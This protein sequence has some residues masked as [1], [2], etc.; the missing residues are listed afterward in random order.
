MHINQI[1]HK[2]LLSYVKR[3]FFFLH[4]DKEFINSWH[5]KCIISFME[6]YSKLIINLPPRTLKSLVCNL[7]YVT[8]MIGKKRN[9]K[10]IIATYGEFLSKTF[11]ENCKLILESDWYKEIFHDFAI[12]KKTPKRIQTNG[13]GH[14]VITSISGSLTGEGCDI[15]IID[16]PHKAIHA[17]SPHMLT[18]SCNWFENTLLSRLNN[19]NDCKI[20]VIM[21]RIHKFDLTGYILK[22]FDSFIHLKIPYFTNKDLFFKVHDQKFCMKKDSYLYDHFSN[23]DQFFVKDILESQYLQNPVN[24][25]ELFDIDKIQIINSDNL[26]GRIYQSW[27]T[28]ISENDHSSYSVCTIWK[29]VDNKYIL[30]DMFKDKISYQKLLFYATFFANKYL[31]STIIIEN[32]FTGC[33]LIEDISKIAHVVPI[34]P[35][36]SK[37]QRAMKVSNLINCVKISEQCLLKDVFLND[38]ESFPYGESDDLVDSFSQFL[39]YISRSYY[40]IR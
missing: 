8:W 24:N 36:I 32:K 2:D 17:Y 39:M 12:L 30:I 14:I 11:L 3:V 20:I 38:L 34:N 19:F 40:N 27:D 13:L 9:I 35:N 29:V 16:D 26:V 22:N 7:A 31:N 6:N 21:Q 10:I 37:Y 18:K 15:L 1:L 4:P 28:A 5:I 25:F 23:L 33:V